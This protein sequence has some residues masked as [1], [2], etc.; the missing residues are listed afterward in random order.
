VGL[1]EGLIERREAGRTTAGE[2]GEVGIG[3]LTV[4]DNSGGR[5]VGVRDVVRP[6]LVPLVGGQTTQDGAGCLGGLA[7]ADQQAD[8]A[9]LGDR[10]R[11]WRSADDG[12]EVAFLDD[13]ALGHVHGGNDAGAFGQDRDFHLHGLE[14][15]QGVAV[16]DMITFCRDHLPH[17]R[18]HLGADLSH[19]RL[20][21]D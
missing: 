17:V 4:T 2:L 11:L 15:D 12:D 10:P 18:D 13:V 19:R 16:I 1:R 21:S 8:Q 5:D 3:D 6:E 9:A 14:D 20:L 7:F